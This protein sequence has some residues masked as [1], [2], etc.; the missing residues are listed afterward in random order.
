MLFFK[1]KVI[2]VNLTDFLEVRVI[3]PYNDVITLYL[4]DNNVLQIDVSN[5]F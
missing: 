2:S 5:T 1:I 4:H 3:Y